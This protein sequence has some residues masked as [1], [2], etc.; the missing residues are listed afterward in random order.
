MDR[1]SIILI[2]GFFLIIAVMTGYGF[3]TLML[4]GAR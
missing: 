4:T 3:T 2:I 1:L